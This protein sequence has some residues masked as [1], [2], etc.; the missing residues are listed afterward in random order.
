MCHYDI[1]TTGDESND[2]LTTRYGSNVRDGV[3]VTRDFTA[4]PNNRSL[5]S[6]PVIVGANG[7]KRHTSEHKARCSKWM[8]KNDWLFVPPTILSVVKFPRQYIGMVTRLDQDICIITDDNSHISGGSLGGCP[9]N[10]DVGI[11]TYRDL[12][13]K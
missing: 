10:R 11:A 3:K 2:V 12:Y 9:R 6:H 8:S 13:T 5:M 7:N 1:N 4:M